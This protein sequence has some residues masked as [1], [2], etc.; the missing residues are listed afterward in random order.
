MRHQTHRLVVLSA[1]VLAAQA[2][3]SGVSPGVV[4][5]WKT[6]REGG[7]I[8]IEACGAAICGRI[9]D[10]PP[11]GAPV[12]KDVRNPDPTLRN[13]PIDG[14]VIMKLKSIGP[15]RWGNGVI[16]NPDDGK[17]YMASMDL[18][19]DGR[20]RLKGCIVAPLCR[21]Q[22]WTRAHIDARVIA[23][24]RPSAAEPASDRVR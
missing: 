17:T 10:S 4:G 6:P 20:L 7:L 15:G 2:H 11:A 21:T 13:R 23:M 8:R 22:T 9:T 16:Y 18:T 19:D 5:L 14:L 3:A 12:Q 1:L 24:A